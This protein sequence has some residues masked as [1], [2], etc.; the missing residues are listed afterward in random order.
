MKVFTDGLPDLITSDWGPQF[1]SDIWQEFN[2]IYGTRI[3]LSTARHPQTDGQTER[4]IGW[5]DEKLR[6]YL[7]YK[8]TNWRKLLRSLA[9]AYQKLPN[10]ALGGMA[11]FHVRYGYEPRMSYDWAKPA[12]PPD[13]P[14]WGAGRCEAEKAARRQAD[15]WAWA[16]TALADSRQRMKT[17]ADKHRR[18]VDFEE[19]DHVM[20][21]TKG[22]KTDRPSKKHDKLWEGPFPI[23]EK[24]GT[25]FQVLLLP[26][27]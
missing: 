20:V 1:R 19:G 24:V 11:P 3:H 27:I 16:R 13:R 10:E 21:S 4:A 18:E 23:I 17:Q 9:G 12:P 22:W 25:A 5:I 6:P 15:I 14:N 26:Q 2:R 7:D 8:Q